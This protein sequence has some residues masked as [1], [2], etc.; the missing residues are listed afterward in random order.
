[1]TVRDWVLDRQREILDRKVSE[2]LSG[3]L[4]EFRAATLTDVDGKAGQFL[5]D[6]V[7][8][9]PT[10][11]YRNVILGGPTGAGKTYAAVAAMRAAVEAGLSSH[12]FG[13]SEYLTALRPDGERPHWQ[14]RRAAFDPWLLVV[15]D[16]GVEL[17]AQ[18]SE[19][20]RREMVDLMSARNGAQRVTVFTTNLKPDQVR[21]VFGDRFFSRL[22][23]DSA[24]VRMVREDRRGQASW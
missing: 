4:A 12:L 6:W 5:R 11:K 23:Q 10:P 19:A 18:A 21:F 22:S 13:Y 20:A 14:V 15:D 3:R 24:G 1:M 9:W 17:N 16:L 7:Q 8:T 2:T